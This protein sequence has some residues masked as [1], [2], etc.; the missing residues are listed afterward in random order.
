MDLARLGRSLLALPVRTKIIA[1]IAAVVA[2]ALISTVFTVT[3]DS[4][5]ALFA[6][7]LHPDQLSDVESR[8]AAWN[9]PFATTADNVRVERNRRNDVLLRLALAGLPRPH[10]ASGDEAFAHVGAL[11]PQTVLEA[12]TRDVLADQ[13]ALGLRGLDGVIDARVIIAPARGGVYA[14]EPQRDASASVRVTL[15]PGAHLA[16]RTVAGIKA[17]VAGG[18]PGL[19]AD[20]V[21]VL[22]DGGALDADA[23]PLIDDTTVQTALQSAL[24]TAF[25]AGATIV[26]VHRETVGEVRDVHDVR[27]TPLAGAIART[28]SDERYASEKKKYSKENATEDRGSDTHDEHRATPADATAR[29][30]VAIFVDVARGL[31][32]TKIRALAAATAGIRPERGDAV[33]VEGVRFAGAPAVAVAAHPAVWAIAGAFSGVAPQL[34]VAIAFASALLFGARP[35]YRLLSRAIDT[36]GLRQTAR[37]AAGLPPARVRGALV[38]EPPHI[39][40]AIISALPAATAAAVLELY[41]AE[42]RAQIVRRLTRDGST[43]VPNAEELLRARA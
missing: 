17:F 39:A 4:R 8:L 11:T 3:R 29:L 25:G 12:Q 32:L 23:S 38:G 16:G 34:I 9:V 41:P 1:A 18:V 30:S 24:D 42:E 15:A 43:L 22:G 27:R 10:L 37:H 19:D 5:I 21:T 20:H 35:A 6:T 33:S 7:P 13:L 26:R 31:D 28:S 36:A 2:L 14:D 40:A